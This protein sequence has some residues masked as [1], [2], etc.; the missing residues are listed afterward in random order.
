MANQEAAVDERLQHFCDVDGTGN[1]SK[2]LD[3][4]NPVAR[5][6]QNARDPVKDSHRRTCRLT[7]IPDDRVL[8]DVDEEQIVI[9]MNA[10]PV[11]QLPEQRSRILMHGLWRFVLKSEVIRKVR[12]LLF[13]Q[14]IDVPVG[15]QRLDA[16]KAEPIGVEEIRAE[17]IETHS[18]KRSR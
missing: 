2:L 1:A 10:L 3:V 9:G 7:Q 6:E 4:A 12:D 8:A 17:A 16:G 5:M 13:R 15:G 14:R 11:N 18:I